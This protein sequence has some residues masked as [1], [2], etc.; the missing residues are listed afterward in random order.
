MVDNQANTATVE[1]DEDSQEY[2]ISSPIFEKYFNVGDVLEWKETSSGVYIL[3]KT[4]KQRQIND[5]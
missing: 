4:K 3:T 2:Y 5:N 1:F